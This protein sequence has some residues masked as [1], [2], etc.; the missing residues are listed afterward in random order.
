MVGFKH[1]WLLLLVILGGLLSTSA[2]T[3]SKEISLTPSP[4]AQLSPKIS[5]ARLKTATYTI[6]DQ[7]T[8]P[9]KEGKYHQ[10]GVKV[11][12]LN[13]F[14]VGDATGNGQEDAAAILAVETGGSG[15]FMYLAVVTLA[16]GIVN[17]PDTYFLGDRVRVQSLTIKDQQIR[18]N[19]LK[20]QP[21]DPRCCPSELVSMAYQ[22]DDQLE[23]L[24]PVT[25]SDKERQRIHIEDLPSQ[26]LP[27]DEDVPFQPQDDGFKIRL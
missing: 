19:L 16:E 21:D 14:A 12:L 2:P 27:G 20:H 10:D 22:I 4:I 18:L 8:Y 17:N 7:G 6:P 11:T 1:Q 5:V 15:T 24:K 25:L 26:T 13:P 9:L 3:L 23:T